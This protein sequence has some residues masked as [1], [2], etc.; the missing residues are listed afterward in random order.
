M[1]KIT[2]AESKKDIEHIRELFNEYA[3]SLGFDLS[4]QNFDKDFINLP[5]EYAP[6]DGRL[7]LATYHTRIAGC[8]A[9]RKLSESVCEMKRLYVRPEFRRKGIGK[10]LAVAIIREA[11]KIGYSR[12]RLD[13]IASF[14][15]A[16]ALYR[17]L[18]FQEIEP[19]YHNP[20]EG[21]IFIELCLK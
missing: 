11:R 8:V 10:G 4:F 13:A 17:S 3:D 2:Q 9:L 12:M 7:L 14:K 16:V 18:G 21:A 1:P 15:E 6:P 5:G 20:I 19:Y